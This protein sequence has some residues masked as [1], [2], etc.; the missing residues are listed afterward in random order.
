MTTTP[1]SPVSLII[2]YEFQYWWWKKTVIFFQIF[3]IM[4]MLPVNN[5]HWPP[6]PPLLPLM[7]ATTVVAAPAGIGQLAS[8]HL[9]PWIHAFHACLWCKFMYAMYAM[10]AISSLFLI[11]KKVFHQCHEWWP[12]ES[13]VASATTLCMLWCI[14]WSKT[15]ATRTNMRPNCARLGT[16][17]LWTWKQLRWKT[18]SWE[19]KTPPL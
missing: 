17:V 15:C 3:F 18:E 19:A 1:W 16:Y 5:L 6:V 11:P 9:L 12:F 4:T 13:R 8:P 14:Y 10:Y 2:G 7:R